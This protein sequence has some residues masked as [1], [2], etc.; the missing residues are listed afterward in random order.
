MAKTVIGVFSDKDNVEEVIDELQDE[1]F[2]PKDF[3]I[4]MRDRADAE[5]ISTNTG[6]DVAAGAMSGATTGAVVGALA[7]LLAAT[8]IPGL[9]AFLIGGPIAAAF[10]L[11]GAAAT[12]ISGAAT[13]AV[14]GGIL[15]AL[16]NLG[17][18]RDEA[19]YYQNRVEQGAILVA[20]PAG[21]RNVSFIRNIFDNYN[22]S[23]VK[24]ISNDAA[25]MREED[26]IADDRDIAD[27]GYR[28]DYP[29]SSAYMAGA[30][31][32]EVSKGSPKK[33]TSRRARVAQDREAKVTTKKGVNLHITV[34]ED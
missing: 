13:G 26:I 5:E 9:G 22:A 6:A 32:G 2:N 4:V 7:G 21:N 29:R 1:G 25:D 23:D 15:G 24:V 17:L 27:S 18:S 19:E 20:V 28:E 34:D 10:G 12:T 30:K 33:N 14:A 3:S 8:V 31:G 11:G 16:M